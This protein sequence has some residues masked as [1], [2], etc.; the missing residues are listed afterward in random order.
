MEGKDRWEQKGRIFLPSPH[1]SLSYIYLSQ[2]SPLHITKTPA[3]DL[4]PLLVHRQHRILCSLEPSNTRP[5]VQILT[6]VFAG[7]EYVHELYDHYQ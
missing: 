6:A 7:H 3:L 4:P 2:H 1:L 5:A